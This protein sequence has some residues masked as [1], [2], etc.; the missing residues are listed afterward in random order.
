[1]QYLDRVRLIVSDYESEGI[2]KGDEGH[3]L[4]AES[5]NGT[6]D[7]YRENPVTFADDICAAVKV[8]DL[9]L[10]MSLR[11]TDADILEALPSPDL[12][13]WWKAEDGYILNLKCERKNKIPY[14]YNS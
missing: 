5:R 9:E 10:V 14:D 2:M 12:N 8:Q 7:F 1:M 3:I 11:T 6:F 4:S 13:W